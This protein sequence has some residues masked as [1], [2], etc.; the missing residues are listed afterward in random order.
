MFREGDEVITLDE[1]RPVRATV[2]KVTNDGRI[3]T[4]VRVEIDPIEMPGLSLDKPYRIN[5]RWDQVVHPDIQ[6]T[7]TY[8]KHG[9]HWF[10]HGY[11]SDRK[12][13]L[14]RRRSYE[15]VPVENLEPECDDPIIYKVYSSHLDENMDDDELRALGEQ[16]G[17][18]LQEALEEIYLNRQVTVEVIHGV[19]GAGSGLQP[20]FD[21]H[22]ISATIIGTAD[23]VWEST[24]EAFCIAAT[25]SE[26]Q[27]GGMT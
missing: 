6:T 11:K 21:E 27:A 3:I 24:V 8:N 5:R 16:Y 1:Y 15:A 7:L 20:T 18:D 14:W 4:R 10:V 19:Q 13:S 25:E 12:A 2:T 9:K 17:E 26:R 22:R 23:L